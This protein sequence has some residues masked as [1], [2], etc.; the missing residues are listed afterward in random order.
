MIA[1]EIQTDVGTLLDHLADRGY[2]VIAS[3]C[4]SQTFGNWFVDLGGP[5][6]FRILKDRGQ[7]IVEADRSSLDPFGLF[8]AFDDPI[9]FSKCVL[10][11]TAR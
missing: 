10:K 4:D 1:P 8:R 3:Q 6:T 7:Y 2:V 11:W 9:E 5:S